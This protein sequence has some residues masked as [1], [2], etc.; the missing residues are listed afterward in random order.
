MELVKNKETREPL[1]PYGR[2]TENVMGGINKKLAAKGFMTYTHENVIIVAPP[3]IITADQLTEEL[4]KLDEVLAE[5]DI[6]L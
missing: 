1:V 6:T 5:V 4:Q 3:L 2:D